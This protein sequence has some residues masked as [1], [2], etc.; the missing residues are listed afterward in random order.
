M[1]S[2]P[3][4]PL[5][6]AKPKSLDDL[7]EADPDSLSDSD[8][9]EMVAHLRSER[10]HFKQAKAQK[11]KGPAKIPSGTVDELLGMLGLKK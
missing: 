11:A 4:S 6:Q 9:D 1:T 8:I 10:A 5:S 2:E 3:S 7:F